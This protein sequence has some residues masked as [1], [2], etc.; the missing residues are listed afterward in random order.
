MSSFEKSYL[1]TFLATATA[2]FNTNAPGAGLTTTDVL[3]FMQICGMESQYTQKL[4][5]WCRLFS[6]QEFIAGEVRLLSLF[7]THQRARAVS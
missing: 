2:R 4:S 1:S 7:L 5:P 6:R 3:N